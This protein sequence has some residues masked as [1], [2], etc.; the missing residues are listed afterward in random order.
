MKITP[1]KKYGAHLPTNLV[2]DIS[3]QLKTR[4]GFVRERYPER[5]YTYRTIAS[6]CG[7]GKAWVSDFFLGKYT[8]VRVSSLHRMATMLGC[9]IKFI[10]IPKE[11]KVTQLT[12]EDFLD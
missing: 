5:S 11:D 8:D 12:I 9:E 3:N 1:D 4:L 10:L 2:E 7:F 6:I